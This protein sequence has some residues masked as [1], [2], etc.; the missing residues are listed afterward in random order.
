MTDKERA[1]QT[2]R[3]QRMKDMCMPEGFFLHVGTLLNRPGLYAKDQIASGIAIDIIE[4]VRAYSE[5]F[6]FDFDY[7]FLLEINKEVDEEIKRR[8]TF[9]DNNEV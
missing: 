3:L 6:D 1:E 5:E 8:L 9:N 2:A 4:V 7:A